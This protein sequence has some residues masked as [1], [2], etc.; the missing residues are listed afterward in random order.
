MHPSIYFSVRRS[1][2]HLQHSS[3]PHLLLGSD[4]QPLSS[5]CRLP[6]CLTLVF[7]AVF[8]FFVALWPVVVL[9]C[10]LWRSCHPTDQKFLLNPC[11]RMYRS[12][13]QTVTFVGKLGGNNF[14]GRG[15]NLL[16]NDGGK[17]CWPAA[18]VLIGD[19]GVGK[20]NLL[21]RF[22]RN[23]FNLESKSTIGVEFAT[24]SIQTEGKTIKAQIWDTA[25]QER[26]RRVVDGCFWWD[27]AARLFGGGGGGEGV[28]SGIF[29][30]KVKVFG[31][32]TGV[33]DARFVVEDT[34]GA[35]GDVA[36]DYPPQGGILLFS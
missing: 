11:V 20:S 21:S 34:A 29:I 36:P 30:R 26:Y 7:Y 4:F 28:R 10:F 5:R 17:S 14:S 16:G 31:L 22:T 6:P 15:G 35:R 27:V 12:T 1:G 32:L 13:K 8:V 18:V 3:I 9:L 23:E 2:F 24:K 33:L 25:G 19:S